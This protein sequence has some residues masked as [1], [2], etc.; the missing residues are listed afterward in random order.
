M[1][2]KQSAKGQEYVNLSLHDK[3]AAR[4]SRRGWREWWTSGQY[5]CG[6]VVGAIHD[7]LNLSSHI[8]RR[9]CEYTLNKRNE[10]GEYQHAQLLQAFRIQPAPQ[11]STLSTDLV[12]ARMHRAR[13]GSKKHENILEAIKK[14]VEHTST[15]ETTVLSFNDVNVDFEKLVESVKD[16]DQDIVTLKA[17]LDTDSDDMAEDLRLAKFKVVKV[18]ELMEHIHAQLQQDWHMRN[19]QQNEDQAWLLVIAEHLHTLIK[20]LLASETN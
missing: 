12:A 6:V 16:L 18:K 15:I 3:R 9:P 7:D 20:L 13:E 1:K 17:E 8:C 5:K 14:L 11:N 19:V 10:M 2:K 4:R